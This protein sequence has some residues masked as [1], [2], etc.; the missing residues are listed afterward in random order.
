VQDR[1]F[2]GE[3]LKL[4]QTVGNARTMMWA[5][6]GAGTITMIQ[7]RLGDADEHLQAGLRLARMQNDHAIVALFLTL[8]AEIARVRGDGDAAQRLLV[9]ALNMARNHDV[10]SAVHFSLLNL[11]RLA[12]LRGDHPS[13]RAW[14][15]QSLALSGEL[16]DRANMSYS[17]DE[18]AAVACAEADY[19]R[20]AQL[21]GSAAAGRAPCGG[22][23]WLMWRD[24]HELAVV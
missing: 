5:N 2:G 18:F 24:E 17:L 20:A 22:E 3:A 8:E 10:Y 11:E 15:A 21:F 9:D 13:A 19:L 6:M 7:R 4:A 23:S 12:R 14:Q 16:G 1:A